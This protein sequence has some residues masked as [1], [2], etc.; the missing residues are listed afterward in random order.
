MFRSQYF[1][2][3]NEGSFSSC[4]TPRS[5]TA[6]AVV[7][8]YCTKGIPYWR[9]THLSFHGVPYCIPLPSHSAYEHYRLSSHSSKFQRKP[10]VSCTFLDSHGPILLSSMSKPLDHSSSTQR[11]TLAVIPSPSPHCVVY[12]DMIVLRCKIEAL[13][14]KASPPPCSAF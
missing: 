11:D 6:L 5:L 7:C 10:E 1:T 4:G 8:D 14:N 2:K 9:C 12:K 3:A 13:D